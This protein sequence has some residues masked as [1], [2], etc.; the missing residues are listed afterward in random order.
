MSG[1]KSIE[2]AFSLLRSLAV[3]PAGVTE[4]AQRSGLP[5]ST[6]A[7]LLS[8]LEAEGAVSQEESWGK[9]QLGSTIIDLA[10]AAA[11]GHSL[12]SAAR[13]YLWELTELTGE[14]SGLSILDGDVVVYLDH[15]ESTEEVQV[16]SWTGERV[17]AHLVPSGLVLLAHQSSER[18][19]DYLNN[20]LEATTE[21]SISDPAQ[22]RSRLHLVRQ[23]ATMWINGEFDEGINSVASPVITSSGHVAAALHIHGPAYRFPPEGQAE[24][25]AKALADSAK[26]LGA[27][28][29]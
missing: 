8:T 25:I 17:A 27:L 2:R 16:R 7:R 22:I 28:L 3:G 12:I 20:K 24:L 6:V 19:D 10:G 23:A 29:D 13:P 5:K 26:R 15:V 11:P 14:T 18:V 1:V 4:L 21:R 9:Y